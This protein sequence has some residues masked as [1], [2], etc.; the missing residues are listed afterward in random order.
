MGQGQGRELPFDIGES[1][2]CLAGKTVWTAHDG[3]RKVD[4]LTSPAP[5]SLECSDGWGGG[6]IVLAHCSS[7]QSDGEPVTVFVYDFN[8]KTEE[9]VRVAPVFQSESP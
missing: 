1:H 7:S 6:A 8:G 4:Q 3:K 9:E 5:S 2:S